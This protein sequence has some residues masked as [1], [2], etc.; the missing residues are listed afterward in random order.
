M[1]DNASAAVEPV[2][3][4][5]T[6][7]ARSLRLYPATSPIPQ[8]AVDTAVAAL[9]AYTSERGLLLLKVVREGLAF[10]GETV[11]PGFTGAVDLADSLRAHGVADIS[12]E[13]GVTTADL[14]VFLEA[15][16]V[17]PDASA[18]TGGVAGALSSANISS[19][20]VTQ[21]E[22]HVAE[23]DLLPMGDEDADEFLRQLA[24]DP[25]RLAAWLRQ[26]SHGDPALLDAGIEEIA[27][28]MGPE[29]AEQFEATLA[30]AFAS[31]DA[32]GKDA[33]L[34]LAMKE[35]A[36]SRHMLAGVLSKI[37]AGDLANSLCDGV[38]G[39]NML[40]MSSALTR[41][42]LAERMGEILSQVESLLPEL[43]ASNKELAFLDHM[44][45]VRTSEE[46]E[47]AL[48]DAQP[49]YREVA[50]A[51]QVDD[52]AVDAAHDEVVLSAENVD[53]SAILTILTLLD[54]SHDPTGYAK[55][56]D[57]L[58]AML[59]HVIE[60]Q[61]V[62]LAL[63]IVHELTERESKAT[64]AGDG[65]R[66]SRIR[67]VLEGIVTEPAARAL[68]RATIA[69]RDLVGA[70]T[71]LMRLADEAALAGFVTEAL[72]QKPDGLEVAETLVGRRIVD[73]LV[74]HTPHATTGQVGVLAGRLGT[75]TGPAA[76]RAMNALLAWHEEV[77]RREAATALGAT[78]SPAALPHLV[79]LSKDAAL[80]VAVTAV[81]SIGRSPAPGA[82]AALGE[83]LDES[84]MDGKDFALAR[85]IIGALARVPDPE[86][87]AILG[88]ISARKA[89][90]K[91][92]HFSEI[93]ALAA[94]AIAQRAKGA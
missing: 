62:D 80:D 54:G 77:G 73:M 93:Q 91:R 58:A 50:E 60:R 49:T 46:D 34:G 24:A 7:A 71:E 75:E 66:A 30:Q 19:L 94:Q 20:R 87:T 78:G 2:V 53:E 28:A 12:F 8:Q 79:T 89:L 25:E 23:A 18:A 40:A 26:A 85:E 1:D 32:E 64:A 92:G 59:P 76:G 5:I 36:G 68:L 84:D 13:I 10:M 86:A 11:A 9:T 35:E 69:D 48:I 57:G 16:L 44:M 51:A 88:R 22:L 52:E 33:V 81:R 67:S 41:L 3:R 61:R 6:S 83:R 21:V 47:L 17:D 14:L 56:L 39:N 38:Y 27:R 63:V 55:T 65:D 43:G 31:Q 4:G 29:G 74:A 15:V 42:P 90:I 37:A 45:D 70:A 82:A 72:A